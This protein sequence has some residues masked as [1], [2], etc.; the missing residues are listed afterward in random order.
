MKSGPVPSVL[1][2]FSVL[3]RGLSSDEKERLRGLFMDAG[4]SAENLAVWEYK[5]YFRLSV[6]S[7]ADR[8]MR[9]IRKKASVLGV[10][11]LKFR[12][13]DL[14][15]ADWF[16]RWQK[17]YCIMPAGKRFLIVPAWKRGKI[18]PRTPRT[19]IV[20][21]PGSAFGTGG[22]ETTKLMIRL[23]E[24][25]EGKF[26]E[27]LDAGTGS[28]VLAIV[29]AK[30]GAV[31]VEG[32][33]NDAMSVKIAKKNYKENGGKRGT[34]VRKDLKRIVFRHRF[35]CVGANL[36]SKTLLEGRKTLLRCLE[37]GGYLVVSGIAKRNFSSFQKKF[38]STDLR[39]R[40]ILCGRSWVGAVYRK[41]FTK[42]TFFS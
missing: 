36:L 2:E 31:R 5:K 27:F 23:L 38:C 29:A 40:K 22:H 16:Y 32:F 28:G 39:C 6:Y 20:L 17:T 21:D 19:P 34:F 4:I 11:G 41:R 25:L 24:G 1:H 13:R 35:D 10:R 33:D 42:N 8:L 7:V 9:A 15:P 37:P 14:K 12:L 18:L 30:L 3:G 26:R